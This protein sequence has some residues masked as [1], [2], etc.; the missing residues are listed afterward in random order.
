MAKLAGATEA[1]PA[2]TGFGL[3]SAVAALTYEMPETLVMVIV[4][5]AETISTAGRL[6]P[7]PTEIG[8]A[9][10]PRSIESTLF[11]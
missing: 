7:L 9:G 5:I 2:A 3:P 4:V 8:S 6:I 10:R 11:V 1:N